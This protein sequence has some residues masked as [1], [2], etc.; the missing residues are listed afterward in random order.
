MAKTLSRLLLSGGENVLDSTILL[1]HVHV[2][3][4]YQLSCTAHMLSQEM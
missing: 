3:T 4:S 2:Y 1:E